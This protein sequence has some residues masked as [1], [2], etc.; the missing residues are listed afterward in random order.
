MHS[1]HR[2]FSADAAHLRIIDTSRLM[3]L[4]RNDPKAIFTA[5][6]KAS[7]TVTYLKSF[8]PSAVAPDTDEFG[9]HDDT[10]RAAA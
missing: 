6:A 2:K 7:E 5:S 8:Q 3:E 4:L 10:Q 1:I 9:D